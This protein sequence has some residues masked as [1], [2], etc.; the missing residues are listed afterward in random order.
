MEIIQDLEKYIPAKRAVVTSGTFDG[1]HHGHRIILN[2]LKEIA[3]QINGE[4]VVLTYWPH[5]RFVLQKDFRLKL[6]STFEEKCHLLEKEGVDKLV[7]ITFNKEFSQQSSETFIREILVNK[8]RVEKLVIGYD[9]RFGRNRE[10]SFEYMS[11][12]AH[13][14]GFEVE[15]IPKQTIDDVSISST[16]I[17]NALSAGDVKL[18]NQYLG[19]KYTLKGSVV[20]GNR[21]GREIGFP[22]ANISIPE[23]YK[24][25]PRDGVYAVTA[26]VSENQ[27]D[28]M[29][30]I[31]F[32]PTVGGK[33]R[34]V[35]V[36]LFEF[37]QEIYGE[38]ITLFFHNRLRDEM[39][40][41]SIEDLR[42][43]L[44]EDAAL[45]RKLLI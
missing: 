5:P 28:G 12:N 8:I 32:K 41:G 6:L 16:K 9:H 34:T 30:N 36:H 31:G 40:F 14:Y 22:T 45:T 1:V 38:E 19:R 11:E 4:T 44:D 3:T 13:H 37:N 15:E 25:I 10:G 18:A 24:L 17:R 42:K 7:R 43:Q 39:V 29:L 27:Y 33:R 26:L 20:R 2:R 23:V 21:L 35:E